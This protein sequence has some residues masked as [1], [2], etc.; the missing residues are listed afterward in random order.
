MRH[1]MVDLSQGPLSRL[2]LTA[3]ANLLKELS[4]PSQ[5]LG[6]ASA[7]PDLLQVCLQGP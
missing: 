7:R 6:S 1:P 4:F 2:K 5:A 3:L